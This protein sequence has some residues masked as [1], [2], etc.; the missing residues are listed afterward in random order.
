VKVLSNYLH[1][2]AHCDKLKAFRIAQFFQNSKIQKITVKKIFFQNFDTGFLLIGVF[3]VYS[4]SFIAKLAKTKNSISSET[5]PTSSS[6]RLRP[7]ALIINQKK[8]FFLYFTLAAV[9]T[10]DYQRS[11]RKVQTRMFITTLMI[12]CST[13]HD[14]SALKDGLHRLYICRITCARGV[15]HIP[16][17]PVPE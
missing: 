4:Q 2:Q 10:Y 16:G 8:C 7:H 1:L 5:N 6:S 13:V 17:L 15:F 9:L 11:L 12:H 3:R 14:P